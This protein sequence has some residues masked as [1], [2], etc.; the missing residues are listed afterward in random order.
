METAFFI[1]RKSCLVKEIFLKPEIESRMILLLRRITFILSNC[2]EQ[3][4]QFALT[5]TTNRYG[6]S[7]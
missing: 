5:E 4:F 2:L 1:Y 3:F 7:F 6:A